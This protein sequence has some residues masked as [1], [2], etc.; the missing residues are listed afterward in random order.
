[1]I[2]PP[3]I[4]TLD[5]DFILTDDCLLDFRLRQWLFH[6]VTSCLIIQYL[7]NLSTINLWVYAIPQEFE[8]HKKFGSG[9]ATDG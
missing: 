9:G 6:Q 3:F 4:H 1:M 2:Y 7:S 5:N 8:L